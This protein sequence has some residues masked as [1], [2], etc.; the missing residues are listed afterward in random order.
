MSAC[1]VEIKTSFE[2][3]ETNPLEGVVTLLENMLQEQC[4]ETLDTIRQ[5][6][7]AIVYIRQIPRR[8]GISWDHPNPADNAMFN[9]ALDL[10]V[11]SV[12]QLEGLI[13]DLEQGISNAADTARE[14]F[15][16]AGNPQALHDMAV[17]LHTGVSD[18][19]TNLAAEVTLSKLAADNSWRSQGATDYAE[20]AQ[21]QGDEGLRV[22]ASAA[23]SLAV[24]LEDHA[25]TEVEFWEGMAGL[26]GELVFALAMFTVSL[27]SFAVAIAGFFGAPFTAGTTALLTVAGS[28]LGAITLVGGG[29][30][31]L[32]IAKEVG[33]LESTA[34]MQMTAGLAAIKDDMIDV[35][36]PW[37]VLAE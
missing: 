6:K 23:E 13:R 15:E 28:V 24:F 4:Q 20:N 7:E 34:N 9:F 1:D 14:L 29:I 27:A 18:L 5:L 31:I 22:I 35:G 11:G 26:I 36:Q 30:Q 10:L 8:R 21:R 16:G 37:P 2:I 3:T 33:D 25:A 19:A 12:G 32:L 17:L